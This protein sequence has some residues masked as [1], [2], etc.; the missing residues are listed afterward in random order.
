[1]PYIR[2]FK[3]IILIYFFLHHNIVTALL[4]GLFSPRPRSSYPF[5]GFGL[6]PRPSKSLNKLSLLLVKFHSLWSSAHF[7]ERYFYRLFKPYWLSHVTCTCFKE[8]SVQFNAH[9][10]CF[11]DFIMCPTGKYMFKVNNRKIRLIC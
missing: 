7:F 4:F 5:L 10:S 11:V 3:K 8:T 2:F 1:M 9:L 6:N